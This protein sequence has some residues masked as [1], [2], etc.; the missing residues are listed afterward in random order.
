[1]KKLALII[2]LC[3]CCI[4]FSSYNLSDNLN[5]I[6]YNGKKIFL[7]GINLAWVDFGRD[8]GPGKTNYAKF[9]KIFK[10]LHKLG[11]NCARI[12]VHCDGRSSPKY[13]DNIVVSPGDGTIEDLKKILD[14]AYENDIGLILCL[15]SFDMLRKKHGEELVARNKLLLT[16]DSIKDSY[17]NNALLPI[18]SS[19]K[20]HPGIIAWE[21]FN[22]PEG[23]CY[24]IQNGGWSFNEHVSIKNIQRF[25]NHCASAIH[26][27]KKDL[28]VTNGAWSLISAVNK[29]GFK[30][31][32]TDEELIK[33]GGKKDGILD[34]YTVHHY[35]WLNVSPF[36]YPCSFW[37]LDKP[38][39]ISEFYPE[40]KNC[41][42]FSNYE[43]LFK[44]GYAGAL[45]WDWNGKTKEKILNEINYMYRNYTMEIKIK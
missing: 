38:L 44:N 20:D 25:I 7:N 30:N 3:S 27:V 34:F 14:M 35:D 37:E 15:W 42:K 10:D 6:E 17:I 16:V 36:E 21:I 4:I 18:V 5:R 22:E 41:G 11:A 40:C 26:N 8:F 2:L 24:D 1:M 32:Y 39:V 45:G 19:L 23:M 28:K 43:F 33:A 29:L 9:N 12:W 13:K 31:Y